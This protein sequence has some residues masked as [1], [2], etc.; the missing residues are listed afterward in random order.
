MKLKSLKN[1]HN[2]KQQSKETHQKVFTTSYVFGAKLSFK[3][4]NDKIKILVSQ[5]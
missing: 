5:K 2:I 3:Y 1:L 4:S